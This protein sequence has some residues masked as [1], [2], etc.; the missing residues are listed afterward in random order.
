MTGLTIA[1][2]SASRQFKWLGAA[3]TL[4]A[5]L[6]GAA[7][8]APTSAYAAGGAFV[9]DD[10][11]VNEVGS[12]KVE[13]W[14][15]IASNTDFF[16][17]VAPACVV[18]MGRPVELG[19]S[20][21][22]FRSDHAWGTDLLFKAKTNLIP[23]ENNKF[24]VAFIVGAGVS[25]TDRAFNVMY[26][27]IPVS[28]Q[29]HEK[30]RLNVNGG[31]LGNPSTGENVASWG[32]GLEWNPVNKQ[33]TLIG[34]VFGF[35]GGDNPQPRAQLGVRFTPKEHFDIDVIYGRNLTGEN[36]N[37]I[38]VGVNLRFDAPKAKK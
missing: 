15:A 16:G 26:V 28:F 25:L 33:T 1:N 13:S 3:A 4:A 8:L 22:R 5:V 38:T 23:L 7:L 14:A 37:W 24:G 20:F 35:A 32:A 18:S 34:E 36:A 9:V 6:T 17:V 10:S 19:A 12:C 29:L 30:L 2:R 21:V 11:E 27:T 31:W